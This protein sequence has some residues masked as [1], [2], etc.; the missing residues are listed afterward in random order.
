VSIGRTSHAP[1]GSKSRLPSFC[2][3]LKRHSPP[4]LVTGI[5]LN[6]AW[7]TRALLLVGAK[8]QASSKSRSEEHEES[9]LPASSRSLSSAVAVVRARPEDARQVVAELRD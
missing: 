3:K 8:E 4:E 1:A 7:A 2:L 6:N 5:T 9:N